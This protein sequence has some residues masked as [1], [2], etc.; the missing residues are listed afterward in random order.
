MLAEKTLNYKSHL[1][2][3]RVVGKGKPVIFIHGFGEDGNVWKNQIDFLKDSVPGDRARFQMIIPDLPGSGGSEMI[4]DMSMEGMA[5]VIKNIIDTEFPKTPS[6]G[7]FK[8]S[9]IGHSMGGYITLAFAEK[10]PQYLNGLALFPSTAF[11]DTE[12]KKLAR[13]KGIR[14]I[15]EHGAFEFLKTS[16]YNLFSPLSKEKIPKLIDEFIYS[17]RNFKGDALVSY[18]EAMMR[19]P[20]RTSIIKNL[21][22]PM[23]FIAGKYDNAVPLNDVL[24]Q[25]HLPEISYF[26]ILAESGHMGM[27]EEPEKC[28]KILN[29]YLVNL[30]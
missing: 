23:L 19:R 10:Y 2:F 7:G 9:L 1:I 11:P 21:Q 12:E 26:H 18:Y 14:F 4:E 20:D 6:N 30:S 22:I 13:Q 24:K 17:L 3:Y 29:E 5:D 28:N 25:C 27:I 15:Q 16:S 8:G